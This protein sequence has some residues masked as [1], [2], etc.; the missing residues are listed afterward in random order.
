MNAGAR[1]SR[2]Y[3]EL[4]RLLL[5]GVVAPAQRLDPIRLAQALAVGVTPVREALLRL[6]GERLVELRMNDGFHLPMVTESTLLDLYRWN[7]DILRLALRSMSPKTHRHAPAVIV[8]AQPLGV[9]SLFLVI[10]ERSRRP[11]LR[12][13]IASANDR[14]AVTRTAETRVLNDIGAEIAALLDTTSTD[15]IALSRAI[16]R[17]HRTRINKVREIVSSIYRIPDIFDGTP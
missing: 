13:Q 7:V 12:A 2:A 14:L 5:S 1:A 11:E 9:D 4:K 3:D 8:P 6:V 16:T 15:A 17:Y 10:A